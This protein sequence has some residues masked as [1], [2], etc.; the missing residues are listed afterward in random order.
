MRSDFLLADGSCPC[1]P[2]Q[3]H[4]AEPPKLSGLALSDGERTR[5]QCRYPWMMLLFD[6]TS[7]MVPYPKC[8]VCPTCSA[9][10]R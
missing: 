2:E 8:N 7:D 4:R 3:E 10:N 9:K 6:E 1:V 5:D